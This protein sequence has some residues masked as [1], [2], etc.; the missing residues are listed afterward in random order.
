MKYCRNCGGEVDESD[1]Y[2]GYCGCKLESHPS[3]E[4]QEGKQDFG[5][6]DEIK[7]EGRNFVED[8]D[9]EFSSTDGATERRQEKFGDREYF[10]ESNARSTKT[11]RLSPSGHKKLL[12]NNY[13]KNANTYGILAIIF[14]ILGG[15]LGIVFGILGLINAKKAI[16]LCET[17]EYDGRPKAK[18]AKALSIIGL[19]ISVCSL[20]YYIF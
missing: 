19:V 7:H 16:Q 18:D 1:L 10:D 11:E 2:C 4:S 12:V 20:I 6:A 15:V 3:K 13:A 5:S 14:G 17:G 8:I 9:R